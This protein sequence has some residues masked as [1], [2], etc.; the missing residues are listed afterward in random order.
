MST[1]TPSPLDALRAHAASA[2]RR[3]SVPYSGRATGAALLLA[4]GSW[5]PGVRLESGSFPLT[6]SALQACY[7]I[8]RAAGRGDV[9]AV[10]LSRPLQQ[11]EIA[12][13]AEALDRQPIEEG[14]D[15][16][17]FSKSLP[18]PA[19]LIPLALRAAVPSTD[20]EGIAL[21]RSVARRAF[22]PES[23]FP[24]GCVLVAEDSDG[25]TILVPGANVEHADW[26]R[27]LCAE[28]TALVTAYALD[29]RRIIRAFLTCLNASGCSPCGGCRQLLAEYIPDVPL[30]MDRGMEPPVVHISGTLLPGHFGGESLRR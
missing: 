1:P 23:D 24:V 3:S 27:G 16:I 14:E 20:A 28:R 2:A 8:A 25:R 30:V 6:I 13:L 26:S 22:T 17:T 18:Q 9:A 11:S 10:A 7:V 5:V 15:A 21:A 19:D 4:D 12:W 29:A